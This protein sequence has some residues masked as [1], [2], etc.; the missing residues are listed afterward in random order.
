MV[1]STD[2]VDIHLSSRCVCSAIR[3][4]LAKTLRGAPGGRAD[5]PVGEAWFDRVVI[6]PTEL[7]DPATP[8]HTLISSPAV[9]RRYRPERVIASTDAVDRDALDAS[10]EVLHLFRRADLLRIEATTNVA[11][12]DGSILIHRVQHMVRSSVTPKEWPSEDRRSTIVFVTR[13]ST[14]SV[15]HELLRMLTDAKAPQTER[16]PVESSDGD[17]AMFEVRR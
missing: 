17:I 12:L 6:E 11:D 1:E 4:G 5:E 2:E 14:E 16:L 10:S 7:A 15:P 13:E 9:A 3:G 8:S